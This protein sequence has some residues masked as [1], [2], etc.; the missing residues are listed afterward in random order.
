ME[1]DPVGWAVRTAHLHG[2]T[3]TASESAVRTASGAVVV[4]IGDVVV[5]LHR[6]GT[7]GEALTARLE[8]AAGSGGGAGSLPCLLAPLVA[9]PLPAPDG[10]WASIWPRIDPVPSDPAS[11]PWAAAARLLAVLHTAQLPPTAEPPTAEPDAAGPD[12]AGLPEHGARDRLRRAVT[13]LRTDRA[14]TRAAAPLPAVDVVL[15]AADVVLTAAAGLTAAAWTPG[16]AARPHTV[17]HGDFHLGQLGRPVSATARPQPG[18]LLIDIDDLGTGDPVWDL[19]RPAAFWAAGLLPDA[20][21]HTFLAAYRGAGG[22]AVPPAPH[23]P[24]PVLDPVARACVVQAAAT[25][26]RR[27]IREGTELDDVDRLLLEV[28]ARL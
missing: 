4:V 27:A 21:W 26:V 2:A 22:P 16:E 7:D 18:W 20:D 14:A 3:T 12:A 8:L 5:K 13:G 25:G 28:C 23:D 15:A 10:R 9:R 1:P 17:V 11:A 19:G 6:H 24:W